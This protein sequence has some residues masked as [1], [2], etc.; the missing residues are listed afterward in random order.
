MAGAAAGGADANA[1]KEVFTRN[2]AMCHNATS[3]AKKVGPGL[4]GVFHTA[5]MSNGKAPT[6]ENVRAIIEDGAK[7]MPPYKSKLSKEQVDNLIAYLKT[8]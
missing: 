2:C 3:N 8:L 6:D 5:K 1:G 7:G 4:K